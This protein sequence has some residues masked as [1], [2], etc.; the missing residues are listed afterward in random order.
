[1]N[2][3]REIAERERAERSLRESEAH[4]R[5]VLDTAVDAII[6][7]DPRGTMLSFNPAAERLFG[8][9]AG[10]A[11][12]RNVSILMPSP[13]AEQHDGYLATYLRTGRAKI[14]GIGREVVGLRK[15]GSTFPLDLAVSEVNVGGRRTFTGIV[16][17]LTERKRLE[18]EIL[19]IAERE[20]RRIG[21]D[22]HDGLGQQL[23]GIAFLTKTLQ[24]RLSTERRPEAADAGEVARLLGGAIEQ[25]RALSRGLHPVEPKPEGLA[26][27]LRSLAVDVSTMFNIRC[28]FGD[29]RTPENSRRLAVLDTLAATHLYRIAQEAVNNAVRHGKAK[30]VTISLKP[31]GDGGVT[32]SVE[33]NG[34][35]LPPAPRGRGPHAADVGVWHGRGMGL[36]TMNHRAHLI[37][38]TLEVGKS[39]PGGVKVVCRLRGRR[40]AHKPAAHQGR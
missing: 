11:V 26:D 12:G 19:E 35:G 23:T 3:Q 8:Y 32:L 27:A 39:R 7:I 25:A 22:L 30:R 16:R 37:G 28:L 18:Q 40:Q 4:A 17:D 15:D 36:R 2:L 38:A 31:A 5:A 21:Q 6:T 24:H 33:D 1:L 20:Q 13:F 14:I 9:R 34:V 29:G 10:E